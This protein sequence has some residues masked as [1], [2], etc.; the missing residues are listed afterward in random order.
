MIE[1]SYWIGRSSLAAKV[2]LQALE[3]LGTVGRVYLCAGLNPGH[4]L[5]VSLLLCA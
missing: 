1:E 5:E 2:G 3:A 4:V